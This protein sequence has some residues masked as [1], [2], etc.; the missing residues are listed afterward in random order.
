[1]SELLNA[2]LPVAALQ[3]GAQAERLAAVPG[4]LLL[5]TDSEAPA[6]NNDLLAWLGVRSNL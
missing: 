4:S 2:G 5:S 6:V 3:L 1:L